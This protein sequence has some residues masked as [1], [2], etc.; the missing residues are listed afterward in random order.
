MKMAV[1][2]MVRNGHA[3]E[4]RAGG[5]GVFG[6]FQNGGDCGFVHFD[7]HVVGDFEQDGG[8]F[9]IGHDAVDTSGGDDFVAGLDGGDEFLVI[10]LLFLLRADEEE[11]EE[12]RNDDE[13]H[14]LKKDRRL[15]RCAGSGLGEDGQKFHKPR[16][17]GQRRGGSKEFAA[18]WALRGRRGPLVKVSR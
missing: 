13:R 18:L 4:A 16:K 17:L 5:S 10:L 14:E 11:V 12:D 6:R 2:L 1:G 8:L 3:A 15:V 9:D 7:F